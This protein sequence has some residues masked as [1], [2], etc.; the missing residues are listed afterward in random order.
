R[1]DEPGGDR[2]WLLLAR[3]ACRGE[4]RDGV[5]AQGRG[6][7]RGRRLGVPASSDRRRAALSPGVRLPKAQARPP[8]SRGRRARSRSRTLDPGRR[9]GLRP[10][11]GPRG[12]RPRGARAH[13][14]RP[15]RVGIP[16]QR[17]AGSAGSRG[18]GP[19]RRGRLGER[20]ALAVNEVVKAMRGAIDGFAGRH[21]IVVGDLILDEYLFGKP[22]RISREAPVL[23][24]RFSERQVFLRGGG[25]AGPHVSTRR[26]R[27]TPV[28]VIGPDGA[29]EE[30][31]A[32]FRGAGI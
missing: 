22:G 23:I 3:G 18:R 21:V 25:P 13:G 17:V 6:P 29:G 1:R 12:G 30:L 10:R 5:A 31:L 24:L 27:V 11:R 7:T 26:P 28:G 20:G 2:A 16:A 14:L 4:R 19:S 32:L 8:P 15:G 9:Q